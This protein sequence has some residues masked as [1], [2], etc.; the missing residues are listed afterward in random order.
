MN[1]LRKLTACVLNPMFRATLVGHGVAA[2]TEHETILRQLRC[3][4]VVDIGANRGQFALVARHCFP[5]AKI[6]AFEPLAGPANKFCSVFAG[7][8]KVIL[9][10]VAVGPTV[11]EATIHLSGRDDSSSLLQITEAQ[12]TIFPGTAEVSTALIQVGPL[13]SFISVDEIISP[14]LLKLDVQGFELQALEGCVTQL[15]RF[16]WVY[17]ECSF[18]ELYA[19]QALAGEIVSWL[20][21]RGFD[22][23]GVYNMSYDRIG[24]AVQADFLF[25]AHTATCVS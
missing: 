12:N 21:E 4:T 23:A 3:R 13:D 22:L 19:G 8:S 7:D 9:Y 1:K 10:R 20:R 25:R 5:E 18:I 16:S 24:R 14:S 6:I 15:S 11:G 2:G 17:A